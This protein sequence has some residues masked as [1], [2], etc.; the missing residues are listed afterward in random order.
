MPSFLGKLERADKHLEY[1]KAAIDDYAGIDQSDRPYLA[2][3]TVEGK[4][5]LDTFR[6]QFV[7]QVANT[8]VPFI[9][10][11][12]IYNMRSALEHL[13]AA[14]V[15]AKKRDSVTFPIFWRGV[16]L[17]DVPG[18]N[19]QRIKDRRRWTTIAGE[20]PDG[21]IAYLKRL[22]PPDEAPHAQT[23]HALRLLNQLSNNDRHTKLPL[24]AAGLDRSVLRNY[25]SDG[26]YI[27]GLAVP[28]AGCFFEN[29]AKLNVPEEP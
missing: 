10:A 24:F 26:T 9:A 21:A 23:P 16:W 11:D 29:G 18:D 3:K 28:N 7:R 8:T 2:A 17:P 14:M 22:Q 25:L 1:L 6:V 15:S 12:A 27:D 20:L 13:M 19:T 5:K 4:Q